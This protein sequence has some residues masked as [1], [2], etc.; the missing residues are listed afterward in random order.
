MYIGLQGT[1][2]F[3]SICPSNCGRLKKC[4][5]CST[6]VEYSGP[7]P[8]T[9]VVASR[10]GSELGHMTC[11]GYKNDGETVRSP[12][13]KGIARMKMHACAFAVAVRLCLGCW[14]MRDTGSR[15]GY[16]T[17]TPDTRATDMPW[18]PTEVRSHSLRG[19]L[20]KDGGRH[21][22]PISR[23]SVPQCA[24]ST[25]ASLPSL[26]QAELLLSSVPE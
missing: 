21:A 8:Y 12:P 5:Q 9:W 2:W 20:A 19:S 23:C 16:M 3:L 17:L 6:P 15:S 24:P 18:I 22:N 10:S 11:F 4:P 13:S 7:L 26:E 25:W 14:K 1:N